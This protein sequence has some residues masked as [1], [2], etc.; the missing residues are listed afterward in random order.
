MNKIQ[1]DTQNSIMDE[2]LL[3]L[4][5]K[6]NRELPMEEKCRQTR[7][8]ILLMRQEDMKEHEQYIQ[9]IQSYAVQ[10]GECREGSPDEAKQWL[11][12][13]IDSRPEDGTDKRL[14]EIGWC[15][16]RLSYVCEK[17]EK[18]YENAIM[19]FQKHL[20]II[21]RVYGEESDYAS[22]EFD[23]LA[24]LYA[25]SGDMKTAYDYKVKS[26]ITYLKVN[27]TFQK[28]PQFLRPVIL[29]GVKSKACMGI[30]IRYLFRKA[31]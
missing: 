13:W 6:T 9:A 30:R 17:R 1:M 29:W 27:G 5:A 3:L 7:Q 12:E 14:E 2:I 19:Y 23:E 10:V 8:A 11:L 31:K 4:Q 21:Q 28:I 15:Y 26:A 18:D 25:A 24:E 20:A 22:D 16:K